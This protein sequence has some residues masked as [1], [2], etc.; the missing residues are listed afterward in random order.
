MTDVKEVKGVHQMMMGMF[1]R[2]EML[3]F[4]DKRVSH[5]EPIKMK[6]KI[7]LYSDWSKTRKE[8]KMN[9]SSSNHDYDF[10]GCF[11]IGLLIRPNREIGCL[12]HLTM[13]FSL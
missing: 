13:S 6:N 3:N 1:T 7:K 2:G 12:S 4:L 5:N 10:M 9:Q 11:F 8:E